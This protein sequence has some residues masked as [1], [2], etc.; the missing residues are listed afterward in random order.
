MRLYIVRGSPH[1]EIAAHILAE[2]VAYPTD[3]G[4]WAPVDALGR[5]DARVATRAELLATPEGRRALRAWE[6]GDDSAF[7]T[8]TRMIDVEAAALEVIDHELY[9]AL[10]RDA[11]HEDD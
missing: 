10:G 6:V 1:P 5:D 11:F 9:R 8:E 2:V 4:G 3:D 7:E